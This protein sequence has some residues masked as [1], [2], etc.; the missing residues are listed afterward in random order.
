MSF[1]K[2]GNASP[3]AAVVATPALAMLIR[4]KDGA[5]A[6][7]PPVLDWRDVPGASYYNVQ[8][9]RVPSTLKATSAVSSGSKVLSMWP[10][11]SSLKL[12]AKWVFA[13]KRY[14]LAPGTYRWF[15]LGRL[16]ATGRSEVRTAAGPELVRRPPLGAAS[17]QGVP[18]DP[19]SI[20]ALDAMAEIESMVDDLLRGG[21]DARTTTLLA[22]LASA[23]ETD[24]AL[25]VFVPCRA[26]SAPVQSPGQRRWALPA[27]R[28]AA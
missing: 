3:E 28:S 15:R 6:K 2:A 8:L 1:D 21:R 25:K 12:S 10:T 17:Y 20:I 4:P 11:K 26:C 16:R 13:K 14:Q 18:A 22:R 19:R 27:C 23:L 24:G 9:Y 7:A 5:V